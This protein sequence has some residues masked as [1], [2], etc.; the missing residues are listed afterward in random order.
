MVILLIATKTS[1]VEILGLSI[2]KFIPA[3]TKLKTSN[4]VHEWQVRAVKHIRIWV[5]A[6]PLERLV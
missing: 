2:R 1:M 3:S 6:C 4:A 5:E